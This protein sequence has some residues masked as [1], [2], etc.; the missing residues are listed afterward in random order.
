M[1]TVGVMRIVCILVVI[2]SWRS[3]A[4]AAPADPTP[5]VLHQPD[6]TP[7][8][9]RTWGDEYES[10]VETIEGFTILE[11]REG[12]WVYANRDANGE[13]V[14]SSL[15]VGRDPPDA[16]SPRLRAA[17]RR[18]GWA[19]PRP[20]P[21]A[22]DKSHRLLVL[23]IDFTPSQS[24]G[25]NE[26]YWSQYAF[27]GGGA[28]LN[29]SVAKYWNEASY[30]KLVLDP[31]QETYG[32]ENNGVV[33][34]TLPTPHPNKSSKTGGVSDAAQSAV[35]DA[36]MLAD[37]YVDFGAFDGNKDGY[38]STNELHIMAV[39]RGYDARPKADICTGAGV[40]WATK[41]ELSSIIPPTLDGVIVGHRYGAPAMGPQRGGY[42]LIPEWYCSKSGANHAQTIGVGAHELG[43]DMGTGLPDLYD[44]D[45]SAN[46]IGNWSLM[47]YGDSNKT[48]NRGDTPAALDPWSRWFLGFI[49]PKVLSSSAS[50]YAFA[51]VAT[52]SGPDHGVVLLGS[53]PKGVD[54]DWKML[55]AGSGQG[56]YFLVENRQKTGLDT[57]LPGS[58][59]LIWHVDESA[60]RD[61]TANANEFDSAP[62]KPRLIALE[63]ADGKFDLECFSPSACGFSDSADPWPIKSATINVNTFDST[64]TPSSHWHSEK[65]SCIAVKN[66]GPKGS[67]MTADLVVPTAEEVAS[68]ACSEGSG[69][70]SG[71]GTTSSTASASSSSSGSSSSS[72]SSTSSST[73]NSSVSSTSSSSSGASSSSSSS[74]SATQS[75]SLSESASSSADASSSSASSGG[76]SVLGGSGGAGGSAGQGGSAVT[77]TA[78][79]NTVDASANS[80][81]GGAEGLE[82]YSGG[83]NA[84]TN[85]V[86]VETVNRGDASSCACS[87][88]KS[89]PT[90]PRLAFALLGGIVVCARRR[91]R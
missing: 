28:T 89:T 33:L 74:G 36:L 6:G 17:I 45:G 88:G 24:K 79:G 55:G 91:Y 50:A 66:I 85:P 22:L 59:L 20:A 4:S 29:R 13:L 8:Q 9:V 83:A 53:N 11:S 69:G 2:L 40:I 43:H 19:H 60:A 46:G 25:T 86:G 47:A 81:V 1:R 37:P 42:I 56:E 68:G 51:D 84:K 54:W 44:T 67:V 41:T 10:G 63:Q 27:T 76:G 72:S 31:A 64:S 5:Y 16:I 7:L 39:F 52:A 65:A 48:T 18:R 70:S 23:V 75:S 3:L 58:G 77:S 15:S 49:E 26:Y 38:L 14:A 71:S 21:P 30:G 87:S 78:T 12:E 90:W 73:S 35:R 34:V 80:G 62:G 32:S 57:K 61:N 82:T